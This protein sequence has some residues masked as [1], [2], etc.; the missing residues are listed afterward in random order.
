MAGVTKRGQVWVVDLE[1]SFGRE[2]HK[3][4]PAVII[5]NDKIN[6]HTPHVV[7]IPSSSIVP[8]VLSD[9]LVNLGKVPGFDKKSVLIPTFIRSIDQDRLLKKIGTLNKS[10]LLELEEALKLVLGISKSN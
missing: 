4:R 10:K 6:Q 7:I 9:D 8:Q 5:S 1:P 3:K 2:I